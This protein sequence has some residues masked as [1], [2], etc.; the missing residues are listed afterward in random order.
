MQDTVSQVEVW[1]R[2][3]SPC[4]AC[5]RG[6]RQGAPGRKGVGE[7]HSAEHAAGDRPWCEGGRAMGGVG[8]VG[9][10]V[11]SADGAIAS[12]DCQPR[13]AL[14]LLNRS[15]RQQ[16]VRVTLQQL[17]EGTGLESWR[18]VLR[19]RVLCVGASVRDVWKHSGPPFVDSDTSLH[20][21]FMGVD[22]DVGARADEAADHELRGALEVV[23]GEN[24][25]FMGIAKLRAVDPIITPLSPRHGEEHAVWGR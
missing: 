8:W 22:C 13:A 19:S 24:A 20:N 2:P 11:V 14:V 12:I 7:K 16:T 4:A 3:L 17:A 23:V 10:G 9:G 15:P 6:V 25:A 21:M 5:R 18:D 1:M